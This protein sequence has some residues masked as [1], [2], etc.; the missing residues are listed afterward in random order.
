[1]VEDER[2]IKLQKDLEWFKNE[3]TKL[4][5]LSIQ[6]ETKIDDLESA[7]DELS[8]NK[9]LL[10]SQV[11]ASKRQNKLLKVA[12]QKSQDNV[13][14]LLEYTGD[15][16]G[17]FLGNSMFQNSFAQILTD[18]EQKSVKKQKAIQ[19][20]SKSM[21][22]AGNASQSLNTSTA[23]QGGSVIKRDTHALKMESI[24]STQAPHDATTARTDY[25]SPMTSTM[26]PNKNQN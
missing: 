7:R 1:M 6:N 11:K 25:N 13:E 21:M 9:H 17:E 22:S 8:E 2:I 18:R 15:E 26:L 16:N 4:K 23:L 3:S 10:E 20:F 5:N 14:Q 12:L 24:H 19:G